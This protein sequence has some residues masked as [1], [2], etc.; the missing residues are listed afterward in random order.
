MFVDKFLVK[1]YL[2]K[3]SKTAVVEFICPKEGG[4]GLWA[5][6]KIRLVKNNAGGILIICEMVSSL[7]IILF[8]ILNQK[9]L[10]LQKNELFCEMI[11]KKLFKLSSQIT[12]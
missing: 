5:I 7:W 9:L 10:Y 6:D 2:I 1:S 12:I 11:L 4:G 3:I 8:H